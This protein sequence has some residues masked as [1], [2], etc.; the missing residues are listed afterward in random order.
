VPRSRTNPQYN[1]EVIAGELMP[2]QIGYAR[3]AALGGLR[4]KSKSVPPAVNGFWQ[5]Q[6]FHNYADYALSEDFERG[7][8]QLEAV[9]AERS[10]AIMCAEAVWWRCHRR[11][12]ADYLLT[13]GRA[14]FHLMGQGRAEPARLTPAAT[15]RNGHLVYP[16]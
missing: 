10:T 11:I 1:E 16:G 8:E 5:N 15:K 13:D 9:A 6:S 3:I 4:G 7:L 14:V 2:W 12:I